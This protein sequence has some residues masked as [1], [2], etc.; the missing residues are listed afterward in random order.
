MLTFLTKEKGRCVSVQV[1]STY[2]SEA[3]AYT[4]IEHRWLKGRAPAWAWKENVLHIERIII[5]SPCGS[6]GIILIG[7]KINP[8]PEKWLKN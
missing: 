1:K 3:M 5:E 7:G 4:E 8:V 2:Q 6:F